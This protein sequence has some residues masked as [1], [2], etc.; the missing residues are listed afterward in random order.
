M[1]E[2]RESVRQVFIWWLCGRTAYMPQLMWWKRLLSEENAWIRC[3]TS[4]QSYDNNNAFGNSVTIL[5]SD[6]F[7][8][9]RIIITNIGGALVQVVTKYPRCGVWYQLRSVKEGTQHTPSHPP[10]SHPLAV[11]NWNWNTKSVVK[12][13][14]T[15]HFCNL[16]GNLQSIVSKNSCATAP[17]VPH[18]MCHTSYA[19]PYVTTETW[20]V[21]HT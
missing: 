10:L 16:T 13:S 2:F 9:G 7:R 11:P 12:T 21:A 8:W 1:N 6:W 20:G 14:E 4:K 18:L 17:H 19:T 3:I 15:R 5:I